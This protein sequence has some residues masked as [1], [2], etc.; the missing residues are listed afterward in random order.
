[1][2]C[3]LLFGRPGSG[4]GTQ[5]TLLEQFFQEKK[6]SSLSLEAGALLREYTSPEKKSQLQEHLA[7]V[8]AQGGLVPSVFP[9]MLVTQ[10]LTTA[11]EF[12][13]VLFDGT[14]RKRVEAVA[15]VELLS[16]FP[17]TEIHVLFLD[18]PESEVRER[19]FKR[20]RYDDTEEALRIR[21]SL[22][23]DTETGTSASIAFLRNSPLVLFHD[24][25][26]VGS[27]EEVHKRIL[28]HISL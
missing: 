3:Y 14:G 18:I 12:S 16:F 9:L 20:A 22:F 11:T 19:L 6:V 23:S 2:K 4:K 24:I 10:K 7:S 25:D 13:Y 28:A 8:M 15:L 27:I 26:G 21:L 1:M 5:R 17:G